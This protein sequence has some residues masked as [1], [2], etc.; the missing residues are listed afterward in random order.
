MTYRNPDAEDS[1]ERATLALFETL[2]WATV[3]AYHEV[4]DEVQ[5]TATRPYLGRDARGDVLLCPR[6]LAALARLNPVLPPEARQA[7][8]EELAR[9]R[10]A[11]T[12]AHAN[13]EVYGL[14]KEGVPVTYRDSEGEERFDRRGL[15]PA[16]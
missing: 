10:S 12:L 1:L 13:R 7:A 4:Y 6:L 2:G 3:N 11:M 16:R 9:D 14:L 8:V 5:A 15:H